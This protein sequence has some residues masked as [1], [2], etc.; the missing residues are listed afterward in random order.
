M[1]F[2]EKLSAQIKSSPFYCRPLALLSAAFLV[3]LFFYVLNFILFFVFLLSVLIYSTFLF[4]S[5]RTVF[6][7]KNPLAFLLI[8]AT[9]SAPLVSLPDTVNAWRLEKH[10]GTVSEVK[11][12]IESTYYSESFGSMHEVRLKEINGK[13]VGGKAILEI[14]EQLEFVPYDTVTVNAYVTDAL[15]TVGRTERLH[16]ISKNIYLELTTDTVKS[17][18]D[19]NKRGFLYG[20]YKIKESM[21][22]FL[23]DCLS[24]SA[25]DYAIALFVGD[26]SSLPMSLRRDMSALGISHILAVSGMHTSMIAVMVGFLLDRA[27]SGRKI[28]AVAVSLAGLAFMCIAGLSPCVVRTVIMLILSVIPCFFGRRGDS[29]TALMMSAVIICLFSP[30]SILSCS[31][32]LSFFATLGIV[33]SASYISKRARGELYKSRSGEMKRLYKAFRPIVLAAIVSTSAS[34]F[35]VPVLALYFGQVSFISV[36][37]NFV[38]VPCSDYSMILLAAVFFTGKIPI[39][40]K[41]SVFLFESLYKFLV[42][43]SRFMAANFE[44]T[45]SLRYPFFAVLLI[46]FLSV[47]LYL[48]LRGDRNPAAPLAVFLICTVIFSTSVQIH[49]ASVS[50][51][52]EVIF[53]ANESSEGLLVT[54][55]E[56]SLYIDIGNGSKTLPLNSIDYTETRYYQTKLSA[57]MLTHYHSSHIG[58]LKYIISSTFVEKIYLPEP[59]TESERSFYESVIKVI[60]G[61]TETVRYIRGES[62]D[63]EGATVETLPFTLLERSQHP[64]FAVRI[65]FGQRSLVWLGQSVMESDAAFYLSRMLADCKTVILGSHG[66]V[67]KENLKLFSPSDVNV[68]VSPYE[69]S[70]ETDIFAGGSFN[71][72]FSDNG[73][74]VTAIFGFNS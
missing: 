60:D 66:P 37:A 12:V 72:L 15:G 53:T 45:V 42:A 58:T 14:T 54:S 36:A 46:L 10:H 47:M 23:R 68:Y 44:S 24:P 18:T 11:A 57:Y 3:A 34:A 73:G 64:P 61:R 26:T 5:G 35:T 22:D 30:S 40:G 52:G 17:V 41:A 16:R 8:A 43:F 27:K 67:T 21:S 56:D 33:L 9:L 70:A 59:E 48:R 20:T 4:I 25:A 38:A 32:L 50:D 6:K 63:F 74:L 19:E 65:S 71:Y 51:R 1:N 13:R 49:S 39:I 2:T 29:I 28:K 31:F 62:V 7:L 69:D 55:G